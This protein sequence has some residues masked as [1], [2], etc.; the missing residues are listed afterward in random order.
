MKTNRTRQQNDRNTWKPLLIVSIDNIVRQSFEEY[1]S[2]KRQYES[3][4]MVQWPPMHPLLP[5]KN[6]RLDDDDIINK[7]K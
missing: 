4:P 1:L 5:F 3:R 7:N 6:R 2:S